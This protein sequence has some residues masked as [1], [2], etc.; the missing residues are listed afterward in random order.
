[1]AP[2]TDEEFDR[3]IDGVSVGVEAALRMNSWKSYATVAQLHYPDRISIQGLVSME[4]K[5][6]TFEVLYEFGKTLAANGFSV[7]TAVY[8][9]AESLAGDGKPCLFISGCTADDRRNAVRIH[10]MQT[11]WR[12][13]LRPTETVR[14]SCR[15]SQFEGQTSAGEVMRGLRG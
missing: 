15:N 3:Q 2:I 9:T 8:V 4:G 13:I 14:Y 5:L 6:E 7:P 12:K 1:M 10:V 11:R